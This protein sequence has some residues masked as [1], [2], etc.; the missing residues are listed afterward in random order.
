MCRCGSLVIDSL[1]AARRIADFAEAEG[2]AKIELTRRPTSNHMGAVIADAVLQA[3]LNYSKV[4]RPRI[5]AILRDH[6][7]KDRTSALAR[8]VAQ[9]RTSEFLNWE[10]SEKVGRFNSLIALLSRARVECVEDLRLKITEGSFRTDLQAVRGIGPKTVDYLGC[11]VG[12]DAIAVDRH[13]RRF[14][15]KCG[16]INDDYEFLHLAFSYA[17]D[18]LSISRR[19]FDA[20]IWRSQSVRTSQVSVKR[21]TSY[22]ENQML[23]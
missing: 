12:I 2:V 10:H 20:W 23:V 17:A 18:L 5:H 19:D 9:Q 11:L 22:S 8:L 4:V 15:S 7:D 1:R 21:R 3:G 6:P 16:V 14:A 13:V